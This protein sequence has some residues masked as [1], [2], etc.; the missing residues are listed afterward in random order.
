[1]LVPGIGKSVNG[2]AALAVARR[3]QPAALRVHEARRRAVRGELHGA[4]GRVP[5]RAAAAAA[6]ARPRLP[7]A[8]RA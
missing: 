1:M 3:R 6:D 2:V 5:A 4:Q 7:A 8:V